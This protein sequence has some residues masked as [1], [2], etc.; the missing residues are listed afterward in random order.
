MAA[1]LSKK[2]WIKRPPIWPLNNRRL[3]NNKNDIY[4]PTYELFWLPVDLRLKLQNLISEWLIWKSIK[5]KI[6]QKQE[7]QQQNI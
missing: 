3:K 4:V 1:Y 5:M 6:G 7:R 2:I